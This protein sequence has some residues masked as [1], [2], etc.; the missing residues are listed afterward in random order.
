MLDC[1]WEL[2][3]QAFMKDGSG[4]YIILTLFAC[5]WGL[6]LTSPRTIFLHF[7]PLFFS[8]LLCF[9]WF[10]DQPSLQTSHVFSF[11]FVSKFFSSV[12]SEHRDT[13]GFVCPLGLFCL[14]SSSLLFHLNSLRISGTF[15]LWFETNQPLLLELACKHSLV[16]HYFCS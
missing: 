13:T 1:W 11:L 10:P 2:K 15:Q 6:T 16:C 8:F 3:L 5:W 7:S 9:R 14:H 4:F 12:G